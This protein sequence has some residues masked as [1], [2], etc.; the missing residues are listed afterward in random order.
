MI[1]GACSVFR[2]VLGWHKERAEKGMQKTGSRRKSSMGEEQ[3]VTHHLP[4]P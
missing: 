3:G 1:K 4:R 2:Q